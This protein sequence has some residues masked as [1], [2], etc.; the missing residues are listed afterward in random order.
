MSATNM[1]TSMSVSPNTQGLKRNHK[2]M[3]TGWSDRISAYHDARQVHD[4]LL[5]DDGSVDSDDMSDDDKDDSDMDDSREAIE[6]YYNEVVPD[7]DYD[8][9]E[10]IIQEENQ[11]QQDEM[12]DDLHQKGELVNLIT[13]LNLTGKHDDG[14]DYWEQPEQEQYLL[15]LAEKW[16]DF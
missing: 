9:D 12:F 4:C 13:T 11:R 7:N 1:S 8:H 10:E 14:D 15:Y 2:E 3:T 5:R 6:W 16:V